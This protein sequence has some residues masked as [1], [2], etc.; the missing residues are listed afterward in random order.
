MSSETKNSAKNP[1][2]KILVVRNDKLGDFIL[3]FP[4]FALLKR[5]L[6]TAEIHALVPAY[7]A[8]A[9][10]MCADIDHI[11]LDTDS[12]GIQKSV[13]DLA[14]EIRQQN[15][16][17]VISLYS[18]TRVGVAVWLAGVPCRIAPA[19]K[20]AQLFY[21]RRIKQ[22]RSQSRKPESEY[23][24]DL[25][26]AFITYQG[27]NVNNKIDTPC[28]E[29]DST[30]LQQTRA[31]FIRKFKLN[32]ADKLVFIHPG[33]GGSAKNLSLAQYATLLNSLQS[34]HAFVIVI[35]CAPDEQPIANELAKQ[36][37]G[38]HIIYVSDAGLRK[39]IEHIALADLFISGSTGPLHIAGAL[40]VPTVGFY[41]RRQ[42]ATALRWQTLNSQSRR[43]AVSPPSEADEEDMRSI[44]AAAVAANVSKIFLC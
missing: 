11:L 29:I 4:A 10:E 6:P 38:R 28:L 2:E 12:N 17:A 37:S 14:S 36:L 43:L 13:R 39:F 23:N 34:A 24:A 7:T 26:R 8:P 25:A 18:T 9:A 1:P 15:Y 27:I 19:T 44:D 30:H 16:T 5:N 3:S 40:D 41:P 31:D 33:S 32:D 35:S 21:N 42:S 20:L 22:R